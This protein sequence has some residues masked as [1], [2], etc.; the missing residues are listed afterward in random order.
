MF[1]ILLLTRQGI[2]NAVLFTPALGRLKKRFPDSK[3]D[4][5]V[6]PFG[7]EAVFSHNRHID[8]IFFITG[9]LG[10]Q[11]KLMTKLARRRYD[12]V[13]MLYPSGI[14]TALTAMATGAPARIGHRFGLSGLFLTDS[15]RPAAGLHDVHQNLGLLKFLNIEPADDEISP[16]YDVSEEEERFSRGFFDRHGV[17]RSSFV[18]GVHPACGAH[19]RALGIK[20]WPAQNFAKLLRMIKERHEDAFFVISGWKD[21]R[22]HI[23]EI[24]N[25]CG[26]GSVGVWDLKLPQVVSI[27]KRYDIFITVDTGP[28]H[29]AAALK[30]PTLALF[31]PTDPALVG[32]FGPSHRVVRSEA[33]CSPCY[34]F[35]RSFR[36]RMGDNLCMKS[37]LPE[38]VFNEFE[39]MKGEISHGK[40]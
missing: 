26:D 21:E 30:V 6:R 40:E 33:S 25:E 29:I 10:E 12:L 17:G 3:I 35:S 11:M 15:V 34:R 13:V 20:M 14:K 31:G 18:V 27:M 2:G 8:E 38:D 28:M 24:R 37:I 23:E 39:L 22:R 5:A 7:S 16:E 36:C 19:N 4:A 32:P 1:K 9:G